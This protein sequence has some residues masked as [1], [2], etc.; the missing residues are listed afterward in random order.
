MQAI[1]NDTRM[2]ID[3]F[4]SIDISIFLLLELHLIVLHEL[5]WDMAAAAHAVRYVDAEQAD[6]LPAADTLHGL[7]L[8]HPA[9]VAFFR[10]RLPLFMMLLD[11]KF[12][13]FL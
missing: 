6:I 2:M 12:S 10:H 3:I 5:F 4:L 9:D 13:L 7:C 11:D 8:H 1:T